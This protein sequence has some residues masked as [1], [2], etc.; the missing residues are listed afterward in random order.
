MKKGM[1]RLNQADAKTVLVTI[2]ERLIDKKRFTDAAPGFRFIFE[3]KPGAMELAQAEI[4][5]GEASPEQIKSAGKLE[6][7]QSVSA[8]VDSLINAPGF[9]AHILL[10][11]M[12]G[13]FGPSIS[14][15]VLAMIFTLYKKL[16]LYRDQQNQGIWR[17]CG[18]EGGVTGRKV[19][20]V[21]AGDIGH[22][23]AVQMK[24]FDSYNIGIRRVPRRFEACFD[25]MRTMEALDA[26]L[27]D[28][29]IVVLCLPNTKETKGLMDGRRIGLMKPDALLINVG[30]GSLIDTDALCRALEQERIGGAAMDVTDPEPLPQGHPLWKCRNAVITPHITGMCYD[31]LEQTLQR[32]IAICVDNLNRFATGRQLRNRVDLRTGYR[33]TEI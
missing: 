6:W 22:A 18:R 24:K 11:N 12:S 25:E 8:G 29:D 23:V 33:K 2:P 9:P 27:P 14:E 17:D 31:H 5:I 3:E 13:A 16:N 28:A 20:I 1:I 26:L 7:Y 21:G 19:L 32:S 4:L 15:Y 10:T 30:R